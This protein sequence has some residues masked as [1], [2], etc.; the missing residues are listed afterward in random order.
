MD[1][2]SVSGFL[3]AHRQTFW[4]MVAQLLWGG[5]LFG[6]FINVWILSKQERGDPYGSAIGM[7]MLVVVSVVFG[8]WS[9]RVSL[10]VV[11]GPQKPVSN[12]C[13]RYVGSTLL[14]IVPAWFV[15]VFGMVLVM[16]NTS[17]VLVFVAFFVPAW[18]LF[19]MNIP[20]RAKIA[21]WANVED[22]TGAPDRR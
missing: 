3:R 13:L 1:D 16:F 11:R 9:Y 19:A 21:R 15:V 6:S 12:P 22:R 17:F 5:F 4:L 2:R 18:L 14:A 20:T 10:R 7:A 8:F